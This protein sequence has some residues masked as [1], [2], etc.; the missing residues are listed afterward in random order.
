MT[1][2]PDNLPAPVPEAPNPAPA[3]APRRGVEI[4]RVSGP[5][6]VWCRTRGDHHYEAV[7]YKLKLLVGAMHQATGNLEGLDKR[8]RRNAVAASKLAEVSA[9]AHVDDAYVALLLQVAD[10]LN[11]SAKAVRKMLRAAE[12]VESDAEA[13][14]NRH[15]RLYGPLHFVRKGRR[16]KTPKPGFFGG[17]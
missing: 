2:Q 12:L 13:L 17:G 10:A 3:P 1:E 16:A 11:E 8:S 5:G 14:K 9:D 7:Q 15:R 4:D 6:V